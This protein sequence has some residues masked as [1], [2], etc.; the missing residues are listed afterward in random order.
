MSELLGSIIG[1]VAGAV[2]FGAICFVFDAPSINHIVSA[3]GVG[4]FI[5]LLAAPE[6]SPE[7]FRYPKV[8]QVISGAGVGV[9]AGFF[10]DSAIPYVIILGTVGAVIG[11]FA[12]HV[13]DAVQVP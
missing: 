12:K 5:G 8:F 1:I 11:F 9:S 13:I 7:S 6:V 2:I 4:A 3:M 10:F